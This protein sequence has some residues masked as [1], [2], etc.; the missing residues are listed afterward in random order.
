MQNPWLLSKKEYISIDAGPFPKD[1]STRDSPHLC[2]E[3]HISATAFKNGS[4]C[5]LVL[6]LASL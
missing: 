3:G 5:P 1:H 2:P 4:L 6:G